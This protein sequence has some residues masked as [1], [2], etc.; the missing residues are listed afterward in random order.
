MLAGFPR[1]YAKHF[2]VLFILLWFIMFT[3]NSLKN[4]KQATEIAVF[5]KVWQ[6]TYLSHDQMYN[7]L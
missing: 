5:I 3:Q 6:S 4:T 7:L 1:K 2:I